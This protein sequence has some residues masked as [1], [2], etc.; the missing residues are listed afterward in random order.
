MD[1]D[2]VE[3]GLPHSPTREPSDVIEPTVLPGDW[4]WLPNWGPVLGP[5]GEELVADLVH[6][7]AD[8]APVRAVG[9]P[10]RS[11]RR[12]RAAAGVRNPRAGAPPR[13]RRSLPRPHLGTLF[14]AGVVGGLLGLATLLVVVLFSFDGSPPAGRDQRTVGALSVP[15]RVSSSVAEWIAASA[16]LDARVR[17]SAE[18]QREAAREKRELAQRRERERRQR[19]P[20]RSVPPQTTQVVAPSRSATPTVEAWTGVSAAEREFTPGPWNLN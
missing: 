18:Q 5:G 11:R 1:R 10:G 12:P 4:P 16:S 6:E 9:S 15:A 3:D 7:G 20:V 13:R 2:H 8:G 19:P 17:A 14:G